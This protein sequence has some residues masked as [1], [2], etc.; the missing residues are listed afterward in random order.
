MPRNTTLSLMPQDLSYKYGLKSDE[1]TIFKPE[2]AGHYLAL[3]ASL[4]RT[5]HGLPFFP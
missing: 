4:V 5:L 3:S 2:Q 1:W